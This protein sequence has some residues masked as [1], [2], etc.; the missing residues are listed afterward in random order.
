MQYKI[1]P[2]KANSESAKLVA[3]ALTALVGYDVP[4]GRPDYDHKNILWGDSSVPMKTFQPNQAID[5]A[6]SKLL[7]FKKLKEAGVSIPE[8]TTSKTE[9]EAWVVSGKKVFSRKQVR[10]TGGHGIVINS[11]LPIAEAKLYTK[12]IKIFKEFRIHAFNGVAIDVQEKRRKNGA[13]INE[14]IRNYDNGWVF[15]RNNIVEPIGLRNLGIKATS[16]LGLLFG[17]VD[18]VLGSDNKLYVLEVNTAPGV[19]ASTAKKYAQAIMSYQE[20]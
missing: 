19:T 4:V 3:T 5:I 14:E 2:Y 18:I 11:T 6:T 15:C 20:N 17:A 13:Q 1:V 7:T 16:S 10:G 8:F 9:A 12:A